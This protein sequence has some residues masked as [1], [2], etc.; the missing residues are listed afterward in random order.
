MEPFAAQLLWATLR[1]LREPELTPGSA[2]WLLFLV[3]TTPDSHRIVW[4]RPRLEYQEHFLLSLW[5]LRS[6]VLLILQAI[7]G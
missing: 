4:C 6:S 5:Q 1:G 7:L 2:A 3:L